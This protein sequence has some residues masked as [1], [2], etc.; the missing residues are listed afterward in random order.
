MKYFFF[1][2]GVHSKNNNATVWMQTAPLSFSN[3]YQKINYFSICMKNTM[4]IEYA[5]GQQLCQT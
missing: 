5:L 2:S 3:E 1:F 4:N